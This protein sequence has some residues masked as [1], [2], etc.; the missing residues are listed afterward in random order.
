MIGFGLLIGHLAGDYIL[1][2]D[3][4]AANKIK[5]GW[6]GLLAC[7]VH[8]LLYGFAIWVFAHHWLPWYGA[9][10]VAIL[11]FPV[12]RFRL[13]RHWM[14]LVG[15]AQFATGPLAPW[16]VVVVDNVIHLLV[17]YTA[18]LVWAPTGTAF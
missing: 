6:R 10:A 11:H 8:C 13:A 4:Q 9:A 12:D 5:P 3:W 18:A 17:L 14:Q 7:V 15:Q 2:N 1:Q 16:S